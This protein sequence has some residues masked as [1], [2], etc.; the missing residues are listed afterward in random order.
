MIELDGRNRRHARVGIRRNKVVGQSDS[1]GLRNVILHLERNRIEL[2]RRNGVIRIRIAIPDT[3]DDPF[4]QRIVDRVFEY[5]APQT[6]LSHGGAGG[7]RLPEI[8]TSIARSGY[9]GGEVINGGVL[10]EL[11]PIHEEERLIVTIEN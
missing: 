9:D 1:V 3:A 10:A 4:G 11:L 7:E 6:V 2:T 8:A 5:V